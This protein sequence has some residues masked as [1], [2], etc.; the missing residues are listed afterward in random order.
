M[1]SGWKWTPANDDEVFVVAPSQLIGIM[2]NI[3]PSGSMD[4][5][6]GATI[7]EIGG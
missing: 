1:L 7:R 4:F 6:Y 2:L 3:A 5:H